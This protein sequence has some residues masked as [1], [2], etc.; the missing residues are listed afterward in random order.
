MP[1]Y[2]LGIDTGG[3]YTDG[4]LLDQSNRK[5]IAATKSLTTHHDLTICILEALDALLSHCPGKI[6]L[7]SISTTLATNAIAEGK[8]QPV[9][10]F[11]LGYDPEIIKNFKLGDRFATSRY[12]YINGGHTLRGEEQMPLDLEGI[13][14]KVKVIK[15]QVEAF[16]V[17]GYFSPR[18]HSHENQAAQVIQQLSGL[19]VVM[20]HQ[21]SIQLDSV[22]RA[23]TATLN[24][25][26]LGIS[27]SFFV[28]MRS[29]LDQRGIDAPLMVMRGDGALMNIATA[30][31]RPIDTIHSGPAASAIGG[32][33]LAGVDKALVI[34]IGGT[35]TDI[36]II[37]RGNVNILEEGTTV[38]DHKTSIQSAQVR[39]FALGGD[40]QLTLQAGDYLEI[41]PARVVP[42]AYLASLHSHIQQELAQQVLL[43]T[44]NRTKS[45]Q[46]EYWFLLRE[47]KRALANPKSLKVIELLREKPLSLQ[48][49]LDKTECRHIHHFDGETLIREGYIGRSGLTPTDLLHV[50]G[51]YA[52]W[53]VEAARLITQLAA[54][55]TG[56]TVD[57]LDKKVKATIAEKIVSEV[58]TF[59][60]GQTLHRAEGFYT[61]D[62]LGWWLYQE[63]INRRHPY[64]GC[65]IAL[66]M[67]IIGMGA[68][69]NIYLPQVAEMLGTQLILPEYYQVANAIGAVVGN[70]MVTC[71]ARLNPQVDMIS[72]DYVN[73]AER[74]SFPSYQ[75]AVNYAKDI[76]GKKA[77]VDAVNAGAV[78]PHLEFEEIP[79]GAGI[80]RFLAKAIGNPR[81]GEAN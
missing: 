4:V 2:V 46:L 75:D 14:Q 41:G 19:P 29:A 73:G 38:G 45:K 16:A 30:A 10:L 64:L 1:D 39:S 55:M 62:N 42:I 32:K 21:L 70:V 6:R 34:D 11:L 43:S 8:F 71:E 24:A 17:S 57:Q 77:L 52:P 26:L 37:D 12:Y 35:T 31:R 9:A 36:A 23:T 63:H 61:P 7:V 15:D 59:I 5:V 53:N 76:L 80:V 28:A 66:K 78:E 65:T 72:Y 48:T 49:I 33:Y 69:A 81:L 47:P 3:T 22:R 74:C 56:W 27:Q 13:A 58:I 44:E 54:G 40:S 51:E 50:T 79:Q 67:P 20:G 18:N 68:P 60:S 25:S